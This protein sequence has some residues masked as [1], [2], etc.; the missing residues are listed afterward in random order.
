MTP[1][2]AAKGGKRWRYYVSQALLQGRKAEAGSCPR[3][4]AEAIEAAV[5]QA[6]AEPGAASG[7]SGEGPDVRLPAAVERIVL[8]SGQISVTIGSDGEGEHTR[9]IRVSWSPA[10]RRR[11]RAIIPCEAV[12]ET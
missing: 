8:G 2:F 1:T 12:T 4:S 10:S 11:Q 5:F 7:L 9:M 3:V 6:L